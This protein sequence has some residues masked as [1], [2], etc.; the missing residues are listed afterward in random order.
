LVGL[1][2]AGPVIAH[3]P[4][5]PDAAPTLATAW[6]LDPWLL[7]PLAGFGLL[8]AVALRRLHRRGVRLA[9]PLAVL[10]VGLGWLALLLALVWPLDAYGEWS[11][12]AHMA[13]HMLLM[14]FVPP[15][16]LALPPAALLHAWSPT[17]LRTLRGPLAWVSSARW[18]GSAALTVATALQS[19][20]IWIWH[21]PPLMQAALVNDPLHYAM[22][23]SFLL[24]GLLFWWCLLQSLRA[25]A[26]GYAGGAAAVLVTMMQMGLIGALLTFSPRPLY[27]FYVGRVESL[28]LTALADQQLAGLIM[29]VPASL[30][31]LLGGLWLLHAWLGRLQQR[32]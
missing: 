7:L 25:A 27:A 16:L 5:R 8:Q 21:W 23:A 2:A 4:E 3:G 29:W 10:A 17:A 1:L 15:L 32:A 11:L 13:Q 12:S 31:Y 28:G 24:T 6:T 18:G 22:H 9:G 19:A 14:A 26:L 30:P 20:A